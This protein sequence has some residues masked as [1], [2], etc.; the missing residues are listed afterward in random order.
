MAL[1]HGLLMPFQIWNDNVLKVGRGIAIVAIAL[2]VVAILIQVF[3]RYVLSNPLA[4]PEEAAR[5]LMLWMTGLIGPSAYRR[6][7]F[8]A[9]DMVSEAL[10]KAVAN[11]LNLGLFLLSLMVL[12]VA[13]PIAFAEVSGFN[14]AFMTSSLNA[15]SSTPLASSRCSAGGFQAS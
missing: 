2:M 12:V 11:I 13:L 15:R 3:F 1:L 6:G 9:I 8:V 4:W 7:G 14:A 10:P 5:F